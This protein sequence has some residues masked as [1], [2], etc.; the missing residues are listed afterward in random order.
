VPDVKIFALTMAIV[1][2]LSGPALAVVPM[3]GAA[4]RAAQEYGRSK[5]NVPLAD[6]LQPWTVYEEKTVSFDD[7]AER[8]CHY[9]PFLLIAADARDRTAAGGP[10]IA[11]DATRVLA[12]YD[13]YVILGVTLSGVQAGSGARPA[14]SLRQGRK[15]I[16]P[17]LV[18]VLPPAAD[19][20]PGYQVQ[21]YFYFPSRSVAVDKEALL[22]VTADKRTRVF[23]VPF[24]DQR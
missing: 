8:A 18:N 6:F 4:V 15:T 19:A 11:A 14:A 2:L 1:V 7:T 24:A 17:S 3:D 13:G 5:A 16:R 9:T 12:D 22:T 10:V 20:S 23:R 21:V